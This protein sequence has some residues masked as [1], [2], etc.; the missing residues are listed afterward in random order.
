MSL[1]LQ[2]SGRKKTERTLGIPLT[3]MAAEVKYHKNLKTAVKPVLWLLKVRDV[4]SPA[5][6]NNHHASHVTR[7]IFW[8]KR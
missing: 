7:F 6:L 8:V 5:F 4:L 3:H 1:E 2:H